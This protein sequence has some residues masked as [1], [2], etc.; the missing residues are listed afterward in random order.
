MTPRSVAPSPGTELRGERGRVSRLGT[1]DAGSP[2]VSKNCSVLVVDDDRAMAHMLVDVLSES[3]QPATAA[4]SVEEAL[5]RFESDRFDVVLTDLQM[6]PLGGMELLEILRE[7]AV[8][9]PVILMSAFP[10]PEVV[11]R[12]L[13]QGA[14]AF[15]TKPFEVA[16]LLELVVSLL[17]AAPARLRGEPL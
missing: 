12:A 8:E 11:D 3:G 16:Q 13:A 7:R 14:R 5:G 2:G 1:R 15:L 6:H 17:P 10:D 4:H 9:T